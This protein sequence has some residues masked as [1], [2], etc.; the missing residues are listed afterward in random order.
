MVSFTG[1]GNT[2]GNS[3]Y[4]QKTYSY[5]DVYVGYSFAPMVV[6]QQGQLSIDKSL[7]NNIREQR[8]GGGEPLENRPQLFL[9]RVPLSEIEHTDDQLLGSQDVAIHHGV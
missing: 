9:K 7:L 4:A 5:K 1:K 8:G 6:R 3:V 2:V